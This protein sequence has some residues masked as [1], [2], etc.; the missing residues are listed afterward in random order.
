M[1]FNVRG[2]FVDDGENVW[3][4]RRE[5]N[6]ATIKECDPDLIGF[7]ELQIGNWEDYEEGLAAYGRFRGPEY[8]NAEPF[9]YPSIFWKQEKLKLVDSG[10]FWLSTTPEEFS[11]SWD[12]RCVRS[13]SWARLRAG[14]GEPVF[15]LNTHLDHVS[16]EARLR[17][18][19]LIVEQVRRLRAGGEPAVLTGDFNCAPGSAA[20]DVFASAGYLDAFLAA[21]GEEAGTF[22]DFTGEACSPRIDWVL[23]D[24]GAC[25]VVFS[26]ARIVRDARPPL[27]PSDH[28]PLVVDLELTP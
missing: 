22:H 4:A 1:T 9:C 2:S 16:E 6:L 28:F 3:P 24:P 5:L 26:A 13:A 11:A 17:G 25:Q 12:T 23:V 14:G 15:F 8:N 19:E 7:Q 18:A 21:G 27:Y 10:G 20:Y